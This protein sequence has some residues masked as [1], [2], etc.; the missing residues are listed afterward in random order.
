MKRNDLIGLEEEA[1]IP[2][3]IL[4]ETFMFFQDIWIV[5]SPTLSGNDSLLYG[6]EG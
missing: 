2:M 4:N 1:V 5:N 3:G 6:F